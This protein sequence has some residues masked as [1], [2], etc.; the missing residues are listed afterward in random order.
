MRIVD[1]D[2]VGGRPARGDR[3]RERHRGRIEGLGMMV[4]TAVIALGIWL[5]YDRQTRELS[6]EPVVRA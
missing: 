2:P 4:V 5:T 1:A 3:S 6:V